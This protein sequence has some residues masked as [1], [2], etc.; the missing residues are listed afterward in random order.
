MLTPPTYL[1]ACVTV[2]S[3]ITSPAF[4]AP[5]SC[6]TP[7]IRVT[8]QNPTHAALACN[9]A[10]R[11]QTIFKICNLPALSTP[12]EIGIV[13]DLI[14]DC[15][16]VYHCRDNAI[17]VLSPTILQERGKPDGVFAHLTVP[18]FFQSIVVHELAHAAT[19][20]MPCPFDVCN[21]G[22]E[23]VAYAM[24]IMSLDKAGRRAF[25]RATDMETEIA[26]GDLNRF[27]LLMVPEVFAQNVWTHLSQ[28]DAPCA[29]IAEII[30][31][32]VVL[33]QQNYDLE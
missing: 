31:G 8:A 4:S 19:K 22:A 15:L 23:Y 12:T 3:L 2:L 14:A 9:A 25:E 26:A 5:L 6:D 24:Q 21:V 20:D 28:Q 32:E 18:A 29:Y 13:D 16:G 30:S 1:T 11:A 7:N 33:D 10:K 17:D 27:I